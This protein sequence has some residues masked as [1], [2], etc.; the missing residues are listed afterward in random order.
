MFLGNFKLRI[1]SL[2]FYEWFY[3]LA[4]VIVILFN[5]LQGR[6]TNLTL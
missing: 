6:E 3:T 1:I 4:E 5:S 2:S